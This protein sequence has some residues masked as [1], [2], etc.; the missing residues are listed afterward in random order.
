MGI[1]IQDGAKDEKAVRFDGPILRYDENIIKRHRIKYTVPQL[2][3]L[4]F[5]PYSAYL[6]YEQQKALEE[7]ANNEDLKEEQTAE[8]A[9]E[10][11]SASEDDH[12]G[13]SENINH[14]FWEDDDGD[15]EQLSDE[16]YAK[17]LEENSVVLNSPEDMIAD[18]LNNQE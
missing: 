11:I 7:E 2:V 13:E 16:E 17:F 18:L 9:D 4:G 8:P 1:V 12:K 10:E 6:E 15:R 5:L 3:R 14:T